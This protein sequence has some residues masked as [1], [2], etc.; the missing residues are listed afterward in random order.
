MNTVRTGEGTRA[1]QE[2]HN[3]LLAWSDRWQMSFNINKYR[4]LS[5]GTRNPAHGYSLDSTAIRRM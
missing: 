1:L 4:V 3:K 2:D 5:I